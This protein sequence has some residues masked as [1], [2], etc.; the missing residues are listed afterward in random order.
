[1]GPLGV[2]GGGAGV[3]GGLHSSRPNSMVGAPPVSISPRGDS[4][5][6]H[7]AFASLVNAAA[8]QPS[9]PVPDRDRRD[10]DREKERDLRGHQQQHQQPGP[11]SR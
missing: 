11:V 3:G 2:S 1:M 4:I 10:R 6:V 7:D 9:L 8:A 5:Y